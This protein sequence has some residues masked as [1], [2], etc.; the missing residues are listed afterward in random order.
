MIVLEGMPG[1]GKTSLANLLTAQGEHVLPE[2]VVNQGMPPAPEDNDAHQQN[3]ERKE[4]LLAATSAH[5]PV[6]VDRNFLSSLAYAYSIRSSNQGAQL[7]VERIG[8]CR[9]RLASGQFEHPRIYCIFDCPIQLSLSRRGIAQPGDHSWTTWQV[10]RE[11]RRFYATMPEALGDLHPALM[12]GNT[13]KVLRLDGVDPLA[14]NARLVQNIV[15]E[16]TG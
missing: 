10:L 2:Y 12:F 8:W 3:W 15:A 11:L 16:A 5:R 9:E 13:T 4:Q 6:I 7:L 14:A 1:A